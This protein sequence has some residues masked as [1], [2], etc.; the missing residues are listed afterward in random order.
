MRPKPPSSD[1]ARRIERRLSSQGTRERAAQEKRYLKSTLRH[2]G[3]SVPAIRATVRAELAATPELS[4]AGLREAVVALWQRGV[5]ELRMAAVE[6]LDQRSELLCAS[7]VRLV[8]RL[9]RE[10]KTW[11]LVDG[12]AASVMGA[13]VERLPTLTRTLD[14]WA[15]DDDFW[16]RR[17]ALLSLL[18]PLREGRGDF[19]RFAR[20][21]DTM[22]DEEEFF[23]R[24]AIGWV[25]RD[26]SRKR[27]RLVLAWL[28][29][30]VQ[31]ASGVTLR[32]AIKY[33]PASDREQLLARRTAARRTSRVA[34]RA[35]NLARRTPRAST[36]AAE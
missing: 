32:E 10:A 26:T 7:D 6:L 5:H 14:R 15:K 35:P 8:E 4:R 12:L 9:L 30:R 19:D 36:R 2:Y 20:Y 29:P 18:V 17:A 23:V 33:L 11:A 31:R 25:L 13:L 1:L 3:A 34:Q 22:L 27:P 24:K 21:A 16:L 28:R